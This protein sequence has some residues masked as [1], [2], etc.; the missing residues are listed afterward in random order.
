M[1]SL[2]QTPDELDDPIDRVA[3]ERLVVGPTESEAIGVGD[4]GRSHLASELL[5]RH[6]GQPGRV[7]DLVVDIGDVHHERDVIPLVYK[8]A[9]EQREHDV[10]AGVADVHPAV[11]RRPAGVDADVTGLPR[12]ELAHL[13]AARVM[14]THPS[15]GA[16]TLVLAWT[17]AS[18]RGER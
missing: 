4:V 8:E 11:D 15:H 6:S 7:V 17:H 13:A 14:E 12:N 16:A 1:S 10:R 18:I 9:F 5:A 3:R 2:N